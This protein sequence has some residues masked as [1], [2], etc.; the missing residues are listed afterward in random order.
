MPERSFQLTLNL[1][2]QHVLFVQIL[3]Y[4]LSFAYPQLAVPQFETMREKR[5]TIEQLQE[6]SY[7]VRPWR[8]KP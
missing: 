8:K 4:L 6:V 1:K 7:S 5:Q 2:Q 3:T